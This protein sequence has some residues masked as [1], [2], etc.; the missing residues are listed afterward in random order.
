MSELSGNGGPIRFGS[1]EADVATG[2]L[3][4]NGRRLPIQEQPFQVL[5]A[6]LERPGEVVT[7]EYLRE[8]LWPGHPFV[9]FDQ[10][11]NTAINK[12]RDAL[13]DSAANA[14]FVE[15]LPRRGYR[16]TFPVEAASGAVTV[17]GPP[18]P[19]E[20]KQAGTR[21]PWFRWL[22]MGCVI[23]AG[24]AAL[25]WV[26][27][28][29]RPELP[30]RRFTLRSPVTTVGTSVI[31]KASGIS[32]DGR[33]IAFINDEGTARRLWIQRLDQERPVA[34]EG[35]DGA[36]DPFWS[37]DSKV[38]GFA[39]PAR[40]AL[41]RVPVDGGVPTRIC[42]APD[43]FGGASWSPDSRTIVFA[44][45]GPSVL[46]EVSAT[47]GTPKV[48]VTREMLL[49]L[50]PADSRIN[51]QGFYL[52]TPHFLPLRAGR[53]V[54][55]FGFGWANGNLL[56]RDLDTGR[57]ELLGPG[58]QPVYSPSGHLIF[59]STAGS[60]DLWAQPFSLDRLKTAGPAFPIVRNG[61]DPSVSMEGT[62][63][64]VDPTSEQLVWLNRRGEGTGQAGPPLL[65]I[66]YPAISP[67]GRRVAAEARETENQDIWVYDLARGART[68]LSSDPATEIL[69]VWS[70]DGELVA[71]S[72]W[73]AGNTD[74]F[75]RRAD[76]S[77]E[78]KT[79]VA[80]PS[81]ERVSDW[82][83]DGQNILYAAEALKGSS[84]L[85]YLKRTTSG[86]WEPHPFLQTPHRERAAKFSPDGRFVAYL[87]DESGRDELYVR[88]FPQGDRQWT[89]SRNGAAQPRWA[90]HS[91][92]LFYAEGGKLMAVPVRTV[93][94]FSAGK[95]VPLFNH[96][97]LLLWRDPNYDVSADGERFLL[98]ER[99]TAPGSVRLIHV[100]QNWFA[101][102]H[103][104]R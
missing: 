22:S 98:S 18:A 38:L 28:P 93:P 27:R 42:E 104:R 17:E 13:G 15:T 6:L 35:G 86:G 97:S 10:G 41:M 88:P 9:D 87:S 99:V 79:L 73:R 100:V 32:P 49:P 1:Y 71:Y 44:A 66:F 72:S 62:L 61:I 91:R 29:V 80:T 52:H 5:V 12:L 64:Y 51:A 48:V 30:V 77:V 67:D 33:Y 94:E 82:S 69:P 103:D 31:F 78:E 83:R 34:V 101:E 102:F 50:V 68:R 36:I 40:Q 19:V 25:L 92:E 70:P 39:V 84:D 85:W 7:R 56:M 90:R 3:R 37:P 16:F 46:H 75:V 45:G 26:R 20:T 58:R 23:A 24:I 89:V 81:H 4:K 43:P 47:G 53:R 74:I 63:A 55:V 59:Q 96:V 2:E 60:Q 57:T 14:R 95:P 8:R 76:A 11:L 21:W 54:I 65:G